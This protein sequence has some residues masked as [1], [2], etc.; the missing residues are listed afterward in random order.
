MWRRAYVVLGERQVCALPP[1]RLLRELLLQRADLSYDA[2]HPLSR[3]PKLL[4]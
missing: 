4:S 1:A 3:L 2:I